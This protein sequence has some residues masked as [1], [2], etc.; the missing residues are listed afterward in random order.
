MKFL[1]KVCE[2]FAVLSALLLVFITFSI[3]YSIFTRQVGISSP[4]WIVQF[5][6]Y[7]LLWITFL[8]T[9]WLLANDKHVAIQ[10]LTNRL[11]RKGNWVLSLL[12][13]LIGIVLCSVFLWYGFFTTRDHL[14]RHVM[15]TQAIDVPKG[16]IIAVIP[17]GFFLLLL[18]FIKKLI[19]L[20]KN[21]KAYVA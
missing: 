2:L 21:R 4:I 3:G 11:R 1:D 5:N 15:D 13:N 17:F 10:L 18:Q 9:A 20:L 16:Y 8:A 6:E 19:L 12:H 14:I 7:A